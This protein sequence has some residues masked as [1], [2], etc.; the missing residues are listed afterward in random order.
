MHRGRSTHKAARSKK[1]SPKGENVCPNR[2][3]QNA[4]KTNGSNTFRKKAEQQKTSKRK[5]STTHKSSR[6]NRG[7]SSSIH[8]NSR[9]QKTLSVLSKQDKTRLRQTSKMVAEMIKKE[10]EKKAT[11]T[12][13]KAEEKQWERAAV[14]CVTR[15]RIESKLEEAKRRFRPLIKSSEETEQY[16]QKI[17]AAKEHALVTLKQT[18]VQSQKRVKALQNKNSEVDEALEKIKASTE[19][20]TQQT[21]SLQT[22][23]KDKQALLAS[24]QEE[25]RQSFNQDIHQTN[26]LDRYIKKPI[27]SIA[28]KKIKQPDITTQ[29]AP[30]GALA[31]DHKTKCH[32]QTSSTENNLN[33]RDKKRTKQ[34]TSHVSTPP[35][36][37]LSTMWMGGMSLSAITLST[38]SIAG[39]LKGL[40]ARLP[41]S[42]NS[43][44]FITL[45]FMSLSTRDKIT[46]RIILATSCIM[47]VC[48]CALSIHLALLGGVTI[49]ILGLVSQVVTLSSTLTIGILR[50]YRRLSKPVEPSHRIG[51]SEE[52]I[53]SS[54]QTLLPPIFG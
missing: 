37:I 38:L 27:K 15:N 52:H 53:K 8:T 18:Y 14:L 25:N 20:L 31:Q 19:T 23:L 9:H 49:A 16:L 13:K 1:L 22:S 48:A 5:T 32:K 43:L 35:L 42:L 6:N 51:I 28:N 46:H 26:E 40:P 29:K 10:R 47:T 30:S 21:S 3:R 12:Q 44:V 36:S 33:S 45:F 2:P 34:S 54:D 4:I 41:S 17:I 7:R 11:A 24:L 50:E 39:F